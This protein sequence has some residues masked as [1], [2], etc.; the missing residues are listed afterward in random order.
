[1]F[2]Q[3]PRKAKEWAA[4]TKDIKGL[5]EKL[6]PQTSVP[7]SEYKKMT[8]KAANGMFF[9]QASSSSSGHFFR[10]LPGRE[11]GTFHQKTAQMGGQVIPRGGGMNVSPP[12]AQMYGAGEGV[13]TEKTTVSPSGVIGG[14]GQKG[15]GMGGTAPGASMYG[16]GQGAKKKPVKEKT[17]AQSPSDWSAGASIPT[18]FHRPSG[19]QPEPLEAGG[20]R[21]HS[22]DTEGPSFGAGRGIMHGLVEGGSLNLKK[23]SN[24]NMGK[25]ASA[26]PP[27]FLGTSYGLNKQADMRDPNYWS[28]LGETT[29]ETAKRTGKQALETADKALQAGAKSPVAVGLAGLLA[30]RMGLKG[31]K[32][33]GRGALRLAG[34]GRRKVPPSLVGQAVGAMKKIIG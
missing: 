7:K 29:K 16:S 6:H 2:A 25:H 26:A 3:H 8:K 12:G 28:D 20:E 27:R 10:D 34:G 30:A 33:I 21:F 14:A 11:D 22:S 19:E 1:M 15:E 17:A 18:G 13:Q 4:E 9:K 23:G 5:P 32:G 31:A 24:H